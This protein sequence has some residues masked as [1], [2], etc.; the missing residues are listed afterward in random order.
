[1]ISMEPMLVSSSGLLLWRPGSTGPFQVITKFAAAKLA[2]AED[3]TGLAESLAGGVK[4]SVGF[5]LA[6]RGRLE[7][8]AGQFRQ[9]LC[10]FGDTNFDFSFEG[11]R[12][13]GGSFRERV[14]GRLLR[15]SHPYNGGTARP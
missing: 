5:E 10:S 3:S 12:G 8:G 13:H 9:N 11:C 14:V 15:F 2:Q 6:R 1:M 4:E 7:P